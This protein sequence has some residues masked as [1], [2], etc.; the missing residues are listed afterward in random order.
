MTVKD[1]KSYL[2]K[3]DEDV[4]VVLAI[5]NVEAE[6]MTAYTLKHVDFGWLPSNVVSL[7]SDTNN[8]EMD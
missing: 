4:K 8:I 2:D 6:H 7:E 3:L 1:L 5:K